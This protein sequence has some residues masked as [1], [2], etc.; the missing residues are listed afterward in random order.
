M[1]A[2]MYMH[3]H[4]HHPVRRTVYFTCIRILR[5]MFR[6]VSLQRMVR[7][8]SWLG[9]WVWLVTVRWV[10]NGKWSKSKL[11]WSDIYIYIYIYILLLER[12]LFCAYICLSFFMQ[13][14][15][16][17]VNVFCLGMPEMQVSHICIQR[18]ENSICYLVW[19]SFS[20]VGWG[21]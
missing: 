10:V 18:A 13:L 5:F 21:R 8:L 7:K 14:L 2:P 12:I 16:Y 1:L 11:T 19:R 15:V 9:S 20:G 3:M 4:M 6:S 17:P